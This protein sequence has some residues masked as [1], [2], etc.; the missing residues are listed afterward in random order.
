[1]PGPKWAVWRIASIR[2]E[3]PDINTY[4]LEP[5]NGPALGKF[6]PGQFVNIF[7][8]DE[9]GKLKIARPY[10][11]A[12]SPLDTAG[13]DLTI[14]LE[15][16]RFTGHLAGM[17][18]GDTVGLTGPHGNFVY[19]DSMKDLVILTGGVGITP[20]RSFWRYANDKKLDTKVMIID[21]C[22]TPAD[23]VY[24]EELENLPET[25]P[26]IRVVFTCTR[27]VPPDWPHSRGRISAQ[28]IKQICSD[29]G[30]HDYFICGPTGM[31]EELQKTLL[32]AGVDR[33]KVH[34]EKWG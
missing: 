23:I 25:N 6:K 5:V 30:S 2:K 4:R 10:S 33:T 34:V 27:V 28:M 22:R 1:M 11:I 9:N 15:G 26:N 8:L 17:K 16:G 14:K 12:S 31:V 13:I 29:L 32:E 7:L 18:T 24:R 20:F 3:T 19:E 21:S